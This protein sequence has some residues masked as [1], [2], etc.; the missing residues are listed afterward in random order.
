MDD[1]LV[2]VIVNVYDCLDYLPT[3]LNSVRQQT[4]SNLEVIIVDD[5]STDGS[6][7]FCDEYCRQDERFRVIHHETNMGVS[8]PRN[9]G[10]KA[11][12]GEY[13]YFLDGDDYLHAEAIEALV[14]AI[15]EKNADLAIFDFERTSS[16][17]EDIHRPRR[18][19]SPRMVPVE[20]IVFEMLSRVELKG[21][22]S[23]NKLFRRSVIEGLS[24]NDYYSIQDQDFNIRVYQ[25]IKEAVYVPEPLYWYFQNPHSLQRTES[26]IPKKF[27]LNTIYRFRMLDYL[28]KEGV[29][30]EYRAWVIGYGYRQM[31]YRRE[32]LRGTEYE[33]AFDKATRDIIRET[34]SEFY[35][36][37][38][39]PFR[40]KLSFPFHWYFPELQPSTTS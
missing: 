4:Y 33:D 24:F 15:R 20:R 35:R 18:N 38:Y 3:S 6:G 37:P 32:I 13:I 40:K 17:D 23:W 5:C 21:C 10:L 34:R 7:E 19:E 1:G 25:R 30:A 36:S 14:E 27:T 31:F 11:A 16:L 8:G 39:I 26:L 29:E 28:S 12:R 9:T 2:S 22:V